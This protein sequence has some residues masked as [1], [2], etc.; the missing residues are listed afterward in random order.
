MNEASLLWSVLFGGI[1]IGFFSY[2][3]RQQS[4]VPLVTG[5]V[6]MAFPYFMPNNTVLIIVGLALLFVPYLARY[7]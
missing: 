7:F 5:V 1:G 2:G 3:R 4:V 6:L